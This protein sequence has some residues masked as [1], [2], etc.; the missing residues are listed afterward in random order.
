MSVPI[1]GEQVTALASRSMDLLEASLDQVQAELRSY[2]APLCKKAAETTLPPLRKTNHRIPIIDATQCYRFRLLRCPEAFRELWSVKRDQYINS[3]QWCYATGSNSAPIMFLK[4]HTPPGAPLK[5]RNTI[6]LRERNANTRKLASLL[7]DQRGILYEVA[8]HKYVS[9]I[10]GQD[11]YEQF[12]VE[13]EDV[14]YT[15][16][17]TPDGTVESLVMQQGGCNAVATFMNLITDM[18]SQY[19][20]K[21]MD[22]YLDNIVIYTNSLEEHVRCVKIV[23][24]TFAREQFYLAEHKLQFLPKELKLL[25]HIIMR[26]GIRMDPE[27]VDHVVAWKTPTNRDLLRGLIGS[28]GYLADNVEGICIPMD[29]LNRLTGDTVA[30]HWGSNGTARV[31]TGQSTGRRASQTS[32]RGDEVQQE[33]AADTPGN[34]RMCEQYSRQAIAR[35]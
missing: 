22:V 35:G 12:R 6:D 31:Q 33:R 1:V 21:W 15:L 27:K 7:P 32:P 29:V 9:C 25:G 26:D 10:D 2:A 18:F 34:G 28:V 11:T 14:K 24:D 8:A 19:L 5:M 3:G 23:I 13:P 4:K 20:G 30:F 16:M 17:N